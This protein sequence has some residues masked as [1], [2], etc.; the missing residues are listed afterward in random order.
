M[1]L[2]S[3]YTCDSCHFNIFLWKYIQPK[4]QKFL[5]TKILLLV[6]K[7]KILHLTPRFFLES[8]ALVK[9]QSHSLAHNFVSLKV[10]RSGIEV[11]S[12]LA[13]SWQIMRTLCK[14][15]LLLFTVWWATFGSFTA[16]PFLFLA[17]SR[18]Q[19]TCWFTLGFQLQG[20]VSSHWL[21]CWSLVGSFM[22]KFK[23]WH[24]SFEIVSFSHKS[25]RSIATL[26]VG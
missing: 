12:W 25:I 3:N 6:T 5:A 8:W 13:G 17:L 10:G 2:K 24:K 4:G 22:F 26:D 16:F 15:W 21:W 9:V 20:N 19:W 18:G 1:H 7:S 14:S 11:A 23:I